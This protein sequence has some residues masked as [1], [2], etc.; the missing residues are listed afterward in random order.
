MNEEQK[1]ALQARVA[2][3]LKTVDPGTKERAAFER[4]LDPDRRALVAYEDAARA[5][6]REQWLA[7]LVAPAT[8]IAG[9]PAAE[10][11]A[12]PGRKRRG[13]E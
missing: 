2:E 7:R 11:A 3:F 8:A 5:E 13:G 10:P 6:F 4:F 12:A 9:A 1:Q